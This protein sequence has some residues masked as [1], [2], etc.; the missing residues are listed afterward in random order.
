MIIIDFK[1]DDATSAAVEKINKMLE[2]FLGISDEE[3]GELMH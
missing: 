1:F 3:L 2:G